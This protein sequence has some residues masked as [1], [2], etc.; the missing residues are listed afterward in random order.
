MISNMLIP[1]LQPNVCASWIDAG[2]WLLMRSWELALPE[3]RELCMQTKKLKEAP[4]LGFARQ[5]PVTVAHAL[6][7]EWAAPPGI[8]AAR[9]LQQLIAGTLGEKADFIRI[10]KRLAKVKQGLKTVANNS[11]KYYSQ[12]SVAQRLASLFFLPAGTSYPAVLSMAAQ[13]KA[14]AAARAKADAAHPGERYCSASLR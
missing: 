14:D 3:V 8:A 11:K 4:P 12:E 13:A 7:V 9:V 10:D 6:L 2:N 5:M 1:D